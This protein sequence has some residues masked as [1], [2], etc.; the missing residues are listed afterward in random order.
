MVLGDIA[1]N[2]AKHSNQVATLL[3]RFSQLFILKGRQTE[4]GRLD[5]QIILPSNFTKSHRIAEPELANKVKWVL[6]VPTVFPHGLSF[7]SLHYSCT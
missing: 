4:S 1:V 5:N 2:I 7:Y 6:S 3:S